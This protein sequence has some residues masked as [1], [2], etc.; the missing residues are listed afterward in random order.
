MDRGH[1]YAAKYGHDAT[2][3]ERIALDEA[4]SASI[5]AGIG[6]WRALRGQRRFPAREDLKPRNIAGL[7]RNMS[8]I[9]VADGDFHYRIVGDGVVQAYDVVLHNRWLGEIE[10]E[11]PIFG[12]FV[13]PLLNYVVETME[14]VAVRGRVGLDAQRVN[15]THHENALLPLGRTDD[16]VDHLLALSNYVLR[17]APAGRDGRTG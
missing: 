8:L 7:L 9:R 3:I 1:K 15:F 4:D 11:L 12:H 6:Y 5:R 13:R 2:A 16:K 14:P 10:R 17:A